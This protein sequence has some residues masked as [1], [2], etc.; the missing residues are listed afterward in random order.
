MD[1]GPSGS[2][3]GWLQATWKWGGD[4]AL[5]RAGAGFIS[6]SGFEA[7]ELFHRRVL[8]GKQPGKEVKAFALERECGSLGRRAR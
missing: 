5:R 6:V 7:H 8:P 3:R 1:Q 2:E 4:R